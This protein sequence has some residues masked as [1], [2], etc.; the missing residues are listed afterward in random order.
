MKTSARNSRVKFNLNGEVVLGQIVHNLGYGR[1][2]VLYERSVYNVEEKDFV[3]QRQ[4]Y[5][6]RKLAKEGIHIHK[7]FISIPHDYQGDH[8]LSEF[9]KP[10]IKRLF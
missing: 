8:D 6:V 7:D 5:T 1:Y 3:N 10:I 2:G 9:C 4:D